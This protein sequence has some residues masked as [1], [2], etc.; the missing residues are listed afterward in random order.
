MIP[1]LPEINL[2]FFPKN[3]KWD[4]Y[5]IRR[6][7]FTIDPGSKVT[8]WDR[9]GAGWLFWALFWADSPDLMLLLDLRADR[10]VELSIDY[11]TLY[12]IGFLSLGQGYFC[13]SKYSDTEKNY[14][15][16]YAPIGLGVPFKRRIRCTLVNPTTSTITVKLI[17]AW[18]ILLD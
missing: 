10:S 6:G 7:S 9:K 5:P 16:T 8:L 12:A 13:L 17:Q 11:K 18:I 15:A 14:V 2:M 4:W 3:E 1:E